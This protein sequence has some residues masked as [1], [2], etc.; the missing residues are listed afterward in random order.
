L[1]KS[2]TADIL[3]YRNGG[4]PGIHENA[5]THIQTIPAG[6][7]DESGG[8]ALRTRRTV[9]EF[10]GVLHHAAGISPAPQG[11][12]KSASS[13]SQLFSLPFAITR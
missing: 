13:V 3:F 6:Q 5:V 12:S 8:R 11:R 7:T 9:S 2:E 1:P 10:G 4:A